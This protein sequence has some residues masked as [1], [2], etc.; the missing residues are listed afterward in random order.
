MLSDTSVG[1]YVLGIKRIFC[2]LNNKSYSGVAYYYLL[3]NIYFF[4][5]S[6]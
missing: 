6:Y 3:A 1:N 4:Y 5:F 2:E